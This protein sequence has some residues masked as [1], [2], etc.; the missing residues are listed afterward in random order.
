MGAK[1]VKGVELSQSLLF[2]FRYGVFFV[3]RLSFYTVNSDYCDYL[4]M[5]DN[6]VPYTMQ[7]KS[8]RPFIGVII[9]VNNH[10]YYAPLSS[11][12]PKHIKMKNQIDFIKINRGYW[13][14]INLNNMIPVIDEMTSRI[15]PND[16]H[17]SYDNKAY[18]QL[19]NN[20][21]SWCNAN[22]DFIK[23]KADKLYTK[24]VKKEVSVNLTARCCDFYLLEQIS[25][26]YIKTQINKPVLP[27]QVPTQGGMTPKI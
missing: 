25:E 11:P 15:N 4:R 10:K 14:V 17:R 5:Y 26:E 9:K 22:K 6:R 20:Q 16:L 21:L 24:I 12:K 18:K 27:N 23:R 3:D 19:L 2:V 7:Q 1:K 13:G 8:S